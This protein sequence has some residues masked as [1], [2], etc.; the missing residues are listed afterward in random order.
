MSL[1]ISL[2]VRANQNEA[3][4]YAQV[5][6]AGG[7]P[8]YS[9]SLEAGTLPAG[10]ALNSSTGL[11]SGVPTIGGTFANLVVRVM[12]ATSAIDD[13]EPFSIE[14]GS[15]LIHNEVELAAALATYGAAG[16]VTL[17]ISSTAT[18]LDGYVFQN[19][20]PTSRIVLRGSSASVLVPMASMRIQNS[21]NLRF[22]YI[23][24]SENVL[25]GYCVGT[26]PE[27][28]KL[29]DLEFEYCNFGGATYDVNGVVGGSAPTTRSG[30]DGVFV[31]VLVRNCSFSFLRNA[32]K[33]G[34]MHGE[35]HIDCNM[36]DAIY[37]DNISCIWAPLDNP[38]HGSTFNWNRV[39]RPTGL[40]ADNGGAGPHSD[41]IQ[42]ALRKDIGAGPPLND[43]EIIGNEAF[44]GDARGSLQNVI[45]RAS[46]SEYRN[47]KV[48]HNRHYIRGLA[49]D[50]KAP[51]LDD[52]SCGWAF[53]NASF[54][55]NP[56][57][58]G[59]GGSDALLNNESAGVRSFF[60]SNVANNISTTGRV[61]TE[62]NVILSDTVS[63]YQAL[64][65]G[66][67]F[68]P[69][70]LNQ[71]RSMYKYKVD[72]AMAALRDAV[73]YDARTVQ[74]ELEPG[75]IALESYAGQVT[76]A[77]VETA[78][79]KLIGGPAGRSISVTNCQY[80]IANDA[81]GAGATAYTSSPGTIDA[82][83]YLQIKTTAPATS[84][85][86]VSP[87]IVIGGYVNQFNVTT[88]SV[89]A[90][91]EIDNGGTAYSLFG[92]TPAS[93]PDQKKML[94]GFRFK[95]DNV[96][97]GNQSLIS[98]G[99]VGSTLHFNNQS[100]TNYRIRLKSSADLN[101][102]LNCTPDIGW[103][104]VLISIDLTQTNSANV[105]K[106]WFDG[107]PVSTSGTPTLPSGGLMVF[108]PNDFANL[109]LFAESDGGQ[110]FDGKSAFTWIDW[111]GAGYVLPD[112]TDAAV[113]DKFMAD[114][115]GPSGEGVT[116]SRP[117]I[118]VTGPAATY[119]TGLGIANLG[120]LSG[121]F[122]KVAGIYA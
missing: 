6:G 3:F 93:E 12:D 52:Q 40:E 28:G 42:L 43:V 27:G 110:L 103:H 26:S 119:N 29:T 17:N 89:A 77:V 35:C 86:T 84:S 99:A 109:T 15:V 61:D 51:G 54:H 45:A 106:A 50:P 33:P 80:K 114:L 5:S 116:G 25:T 117:K 92:V 96:G 111:G 58:A 56:G 60:G 83:Q 70:T 94:L 87:R 22:E 78:W 62:G 90:F 71:A 102:S 24:F 120:S 46:T 74:L 100:G 115:I 104:T 113:R 37:D 122:T 79:I 14:I 7:K 66:T 65:D 69:T 11:I 76:G 32:V 38:P 39:T 108:N 13:L 4:E 59:N 121:A 44:D 1:S 30:F 34:M 98:Q 95:H 68:N 10:V 82:G 107:V 88:A 31:R 118:Y 105:L 2:N 101:A 23:D 55:M 53:N 18:G 67:T 20:N 63:A 47:L 73:D 19:I 75:W 57:L 36:F 21:T 72:G 64:L 8:P 97:G 48:A 16:G 91:D 49:N 41:A 81:S 9:Y 112:I 85:T